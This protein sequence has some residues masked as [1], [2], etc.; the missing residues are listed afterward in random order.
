ML[1]QVKSNANRGELLGE[2]TIREGAEIMAEIFQ[3]QGVPCRVEG[4][5]ERRQPSS[6]YA[7]LRAELENLHRTV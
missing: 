7:E 6:L 2:S 3:L 4:V 1:F 5:G